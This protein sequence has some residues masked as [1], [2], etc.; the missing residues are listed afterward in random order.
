MGRCSGLQRTKHAY[1][2]A[3]IRLKMSTDGAL[4]LPFGVARFV[5]SLC[6]LFR[7]IWFNLLWV[8]LGSKLPGKFRIKV[9]T[10]AFQYDANACPLCESHLHEPPLNHNFNPSLQFPNR[11][12]L[13]G[14]L[15]PFTSLPENLGS[16]LDVKGWG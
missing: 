1:F 14:T 7:Q 8:I 12:T 10:C 6:I 4:N 2:G 16:G 5:H 9:V 15:N 11:A 3:I 13:S